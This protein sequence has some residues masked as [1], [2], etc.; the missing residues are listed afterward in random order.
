MSKQL[1]ALA[2][3]SGERAHYTHCIGGCV[4]IGIGKRGVEK[5]KSLP[6]IRNEN[7]ANKSLYFI[8]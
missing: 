5:I 6:L 1:H 3:Y 4:D 8:H 7:M 2:L